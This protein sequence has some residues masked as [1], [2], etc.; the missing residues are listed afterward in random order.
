MA[1]IWILG[2]GDDGMA[3]FDPRPVDDIAAER[4]AR[5]ADLITMLNSETGPH[6]RDI[7]TGGNKG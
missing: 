6:S 7:Q 4:D 2:G 5:L 3:E 1:V